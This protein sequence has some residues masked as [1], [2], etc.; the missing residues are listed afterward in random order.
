MI[1][2]AAKLSLV[3]VSYLSIC[4]LFY[5][6]PLPPLSKKV[7]KSYDKKLWC[8]EAGKLVTLP[9]FVQCTSYTSDIVLFAPF[10]LKLNLFA[11]KYKDMH[12]I[13]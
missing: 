7:A 13:K 11:I 10:V 3:T 12:Y 8:F 1:V 6:P 4:Y 9:I 2:K 5:E